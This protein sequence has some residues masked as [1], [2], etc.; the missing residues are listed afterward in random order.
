[1][2]D[3]RSSLVSDPARLLAPHRSASERS[4]AANPRGAPPRNPRPRWSWADR[5][6]FAADGLCRRPR[7]SL[8][9]VRA[10]PSAAEVELRESVDVEQLE[11][12]GDVRGGVDLDVRSAVAEGGGVAD[13]GADPGG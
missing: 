6:V 4:T 12:A 3:Q 1:M 11:D 7:R 10:H 9:P 13:E 5:A 2:S 8:H